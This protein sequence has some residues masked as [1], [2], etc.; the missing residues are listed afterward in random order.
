MSWTLAICFATMLLAQIKEV[1]NKGKMLPDSNFRH[2]LVLDIFPGPHSDHS[3]IDK[4]ETPPGF[5]PSCYHG[6][7]DGICVP[8]E[9]S[10][11]NEQVICG[12]DE[13]DVVIDYEDQDYN[14]CIEEDTENVLIAI[15]GIIEGNTEEA[16]ENL[17]VA[18][19][20]DNPNEDTE[21]LM[22]DIQEIKE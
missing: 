6:A 14:G 15:P 9:D 7:L 11:E 16:K 12:E 13:D 8:S 10:A 2:I 5:K 17:L 21:N 20:E 18:I 1:G 4:L 3:S 19:P 22:V